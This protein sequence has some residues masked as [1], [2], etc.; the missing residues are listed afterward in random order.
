MTDLREMSADQLSAY[1][2]AHSHKDILR[3]LTCGSVDD[4]KSTLIGRLLYESGSVPDDQMAALKRDSTRTMPDGGLDYSLLLDG[5]EAE[6]QQGI[7]IDVAYRYFG[8]PRRNFIVADTPGHEQYTRNMITGASTADIAILLVD[9]R[10]G[11]LT[12]TRRHATLVALT[13]IR[14]VIL[15]VN[16]M[17]LVGYDRQIFD[18]IVDTFRQF[19]QTLA[20]STINAIPVS[21]VAGDNIATPSANTPWYQGQA[22]LPLL[23]T[24]PLRDRDGDTA[25]SL[26]VQWVCRPNQ[27]FRGYAG[28]ISGGQVVVGQAVCVEPGGRT[29]TVTSILT[30]AGEALRAD[31]GTAVML[32]LAD[33]ID[34]SRGDVIADAG[35]RPQVSDQFRVHLV[36]MNE[37]PLLPGRSYLM[38]LGTK[39]VG[40]QVTQIKHVINVNTR[41]HVAARHLEMN[42]V[43]VCNIALDGPIAF[44]P[45]ADNQ[46]LGGFI[47]IDRMTNTTV[48]CGMIDFALRRAANVH[49]QHL[50]VD[51]ATR[52]A[53]KGQKGCVLWFTGLSGSGKST[54]ADLVERKLAAM[55]RHTYLLDGDNIRHGLNRD[56]G[57][58]DEDRVE[59][60]RRIGEMAKLFVDAG[61]IV[62][63]AF[64]SPFTEERR[65]ARAMV[66]DGE[67]LE[68]YLDAPLELCEARD[69]KG[70]YRKA[71]SGEIANFTGI[72]SPYEIPQAAE[73]RLD[74][75]QEP[76]VMATQVVQFLKSL[77]IV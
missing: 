15:A 2:D 63:T 43:A 76:E 64:I 38:Q 14:R 32:T 39:S 16:K 59:N 44:V 71:R 23:E 62:L 9:A 68:I 29:S 42:D 22:L 12:Q 50:T 5:L 8:T 28:S 75:K 30:P 51:K 46:T 48:G 55:G 11:L 17:D 3:F 65:L 37:H 6:R 18:Q 35:N 45:Y 58:T 54:I 34:I 1:L 56:L 47:V 21:A 33:E 20:I 70:L 61:L 41:E 24:M 27:N 40:F 13:G 19:A 10:K 31:S 52:A 72:T 25:F 26:P 36:W 77:N 7:T 60:I 73:L 57:F 69:P 53:M 74:A 4:G 67:F 66:E 49:W